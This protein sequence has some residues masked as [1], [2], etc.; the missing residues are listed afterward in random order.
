MGRNWF[1][2]FVLSATKTQYRIILELIQIDLDS[3]RKTILPTRNQ[4]YKV[5]SLQIQLTV[6]ALISW[7]GDHAIYNLNIFS[8]LFLILYIS[9][10]FFWY[11][12]VH[13]NRKSSIVICIKCFI[14]FGD[15]IIKYFP[16]ETQFRIYWEMWKGIYNYCRFLCYKQF[17]FLPSFFSM[18]ENMHTSDTLWAGWRMASSIFLLDWLYHHSS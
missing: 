5:A 3:A 2:T 17:F 1:L 10:T 14:I 13:W 7:L 15:I 9:P 4:F 8:Y 11:L 6:S 16:L 18:V 12:C